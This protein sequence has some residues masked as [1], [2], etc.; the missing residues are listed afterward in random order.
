[1]VGCACASGPIT[2]LPITA[3]GNLTP[4][5]AVYPNALTVLKRLARWAARSAV[6]DG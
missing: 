5:E 3:D 2:L 1:M 6:T 4:F